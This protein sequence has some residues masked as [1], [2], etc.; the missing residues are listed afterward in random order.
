M[1]TLEHCLKRSDE[2]IFGSEEPYEQSGDVGEEVDTSGLIYLR[3]RYMQP[4]LGL[5]L[6]RDPWSG[7]VLRPGSMNGWNYADGD[8]VTFRDLLASGV[9]TLDVV[10]DDGLHTSIAH[11][12]LTVSKPRFV[13]GAPSIEKVVSFGSIKTAVF[14]LDVTPL[15]GWTAPVTLVFDPS[16]APALGTVG[17]TRDPVSGV[18]AST[19]MVTPTER[20]YL[21]ASTKKDTPPGQYTLLVEAEAGGRQQTLVLTLTVK[22]IKLYLPLIARNQVP[23]AMAWHR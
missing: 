13:L 8:P 5:F 3:A 17:L 10:G 23:M 4:T 1:N 12:A 22:Q 11:V 19:L 2:W 20:V 9:Y 14:E 18:V 7:D 6:A 16:S 21:M 15:D